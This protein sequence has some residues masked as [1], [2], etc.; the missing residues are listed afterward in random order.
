MTADS[1]PAAA[2]VVV[3]EAILHAHCVVVVFVI[4]LE[5]ARNFDSLD[6]IQWWNHC[7]DLVRPNH[8]SKS[9]NNI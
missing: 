8:L 9:N 6:S 7:F 3:V 4:L 5:E 1:V 2:A